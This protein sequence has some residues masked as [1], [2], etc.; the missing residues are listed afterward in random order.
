MFLKVQFANKI[1][2]RELF[3]R[4]WKF[5]FPNAYQTGFLKHVILCL[6]YRGN[7]WGWWLTRYTCNGGLDAYLL[8]LLDF[9]A[10]IWPP[11]PSETIYG[12]APVPQRPWNQRSFMNWVELEQYSTT[13]IGNYQG[14]IQFRQIRKMEVDCSPPPPPNKIIWVDFN[15]TLYRLNIC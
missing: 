8:E 15:P 13:W 1:I 7:I 2:V 12:S 11:S 14:K 10:E 9:W 5:S 3:I 4:P 6:L